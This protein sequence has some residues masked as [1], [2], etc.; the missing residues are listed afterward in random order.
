MNTPLRVLIIEDSETDALLLQQEL[1]RGGY[2]VTTERVDTAAAMTAA[3]QRG[4]WDIIIS[5]HRM[6]QFSSLA[7]LKIY[8]EHDCDIPFLVVSGSIGEELAVAAMKAGAH[9]YIMKDNRTRLLPAVERELREAAGRKAR[10]EAEQALEQLRRQHGLILEAA[11]EGICGL[12]THGVIT[13]INTPGAKLAGWKPAELIG[14]PLHEV[15]HHSR[16]DGSQFPQ[17]NCSLCATIS[18]GLVHWMDDEV[19]WRKDGTSFPVEYVCTPIR[20]DQKVVGAVLTFKDLTGRKRAEE[21][22]RHSNR[23]LERTLKELRETQ[24]QIIQQERLGAL[25]QMASG[26]AHDFNNALSKMLGFTELLLTSPEKFNDPEKARAYLQ[27]I[28]TSAQDAAHVVRRL[29]EFYRPRRDTEV[30]RSVDLNALIRNAI[31][32]TEPRWKGQ[33]RASGANIEVQADLEAASTVTGNEG[34]LREVFTNLIFNAV[35]AMPSGGTIT[36]R[37]RVSDG[38]VLIEVSDTGTGMTEAVRLRCLEPFFSTK[39]EHGTGLGLASVLGIVQRHDGTID[40]QSEA[41]HGS[42]F[43]IRLPVRVVQKETPSSQKPVPAPRPLNVLVVEDEPMIRDIEAEYLACDG[44]SVETAPNGSQGLEKFR[45]GRFDLVVAD[46]A[47][48]EMNGDQ[49]AGAIKELAPATPI[50]LVTGF[51][52]SLSNDTHSS[53]IVDLVLSKPFTH[54]ALREA[55]GKVTSV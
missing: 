46:R 1:Q 55:V 11:G 3:L 35:D 15:L 24:Q 10:K 20:E 33:A 23:H 12:D 9:D 44:H 37:T 47:M 16:A 4:P 26:V 52:E 40:V 45:A 48:P 50:I 42:T 19:F 2:A 25:G 51:D 8:K 54:A 14:R 6:P 27:M 38:H 22:L 17:Q 13:F 41:G 31:A 32:L 39:G 28:S 18:D 30:F 34:D 7:A 5:D 36:I 53:G 29:Q 43:S 49:L 21:E